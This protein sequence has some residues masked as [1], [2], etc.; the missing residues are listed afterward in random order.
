MG[1]EFSGHC[2]GWTS[3]TLNIVSY[4]PP[5]KDK[6]NRYLYCRTEWIKNVLCV[7]LGEG[8]REKLRR[9]HRFH[10][11]PVSLPFTCISI[12]A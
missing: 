1:S 5:I 11:S 10:F 2:A 4:K 3:I 8:H 9:T 7:L 12:R 6:E